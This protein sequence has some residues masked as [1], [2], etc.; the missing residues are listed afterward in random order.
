MALTLLEVLAA[1]G[2]TLLVMAGVFAV[3]CLLV[4]HLRFQA[5]ARRARTVVEKGSPAAGDTLQ[6]HIAQRLGTA[7]RDPAPFTLMLVTPERW[8]AL[9]DP[10][11]R[12]AALELVTLLEQRLRK[13]VRRDDLVLRFREDVVAVLLGARRSAADA[14]GR[15][16]LGAAAR[17]AYRLASGLILRV[18]ALAG[19]A[20]YPEDGDRAG[21]LR[22]K[23]EAALQHAAPS[24]PCPQW[25]PDTVA[26]Q[27]PPKAAH[28]G[29]EEDQKPL[30]D[31]LTGVLQERRL[32]TALQKYV[33]RYRR[34]E[35][36]VAVLCLDIDYLRRY[37]DQYGQ[38]TGDQLLRSIAEFL[39]QQTREDD[40]IARWGGDQFVIA[41][42]ASQPEA[43]GVAQRLWSAV[44]K[45]PF[46]GVGPGLRLTVTIGMSSCPEH[47][48]NARHLFEAAQVALRVAKTKGRN[49]CLIF[50]DEMRTMK[51]AKQPIDAF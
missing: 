7:H 48:A 44:R 27:P 1:A 9:P 28:V 3:V 43:W 23:A 6:V 33:A 42:Q 41:L 46:A 25:P 4:S 11:G 26:A 38:K 8:H 10:Y 39:Q 50:A 45:T 18:Q 15:R 14:I 32:G 24:G 31:P 30:L 21:D 22:A 5:L 47:G 40:L 37:N 13:L 20:A 2:E 34:D 17:D 16:V 35:K 29:V 49:Q 12:E 51:V 19:A 36:P